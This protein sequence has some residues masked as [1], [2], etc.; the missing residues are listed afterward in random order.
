M[1]HPTV[2]MDGKQIDVE[3][4]S[5][6]AYLWEHNVNTTFCCQGEDHRYIS[7]AS[8]GDLARMLSMIRSGEIVV[9]AGWSHVIRYKGDLQLKEPGERVDIPEAAVFWP[10]IYTRFEKEP[11]VLPELMSCIVRMDEGKIVSISSVPY[12]QNWVLHSQNEIARSNAMKFYFDNYRNLESKNDRAFA[13]E[14]LLKHPDDAMVQRF[15]ALTVT[16]L[17]E[18]KAAMSKDWTPK[19]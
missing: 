4:S 13:Q 7:V 3:M 10:R 1:K 12:R 17:E 15:Y 5:T 2:M 16:A 9:E 8:E 11:E 19:V 18:G 14:Q 6:I